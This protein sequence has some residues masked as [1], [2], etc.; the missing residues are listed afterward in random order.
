[1][2][3]K[4]SEFGLSLAGFGLGLGTLVLDQAGVELPTW[5]LIA[6]GACAAAMILGGLLVPLAS[7][8][9]VAEESPK[10][11]D[12]CQELL[13]WLRRYANRLAQNLENFPGYWWTAV[14]DKEFDGEVPGYGE[15]THQGAVDL[16]LCKFAQFF[17][18]ARIYQDFCPDHNEQGA[19]EPYVRGVYDALEIGSNKLHHIGKLSADGW[20]G[21]GARPLE[22]D[23]LG[24]V[25]EAHPEAFE[26]IK[27][28][29]LEARPD[30]PAR[31]RIE[32]AGM[33]ARRAEI[34]LRANDH[35]P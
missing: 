18:A 3:Q 2:K 10:A 16:L 27:T 28:L 32:A 13:I 26:P 22:E 9:R 4:G 24:P 5:L 34:W 7:R 12:D 25:L 15:T 19:V 6:L 35:G 23:D 20:G 21:P 30:S 14:G 11:P 1:M 33:A 31:K 8:H 17:A 29:M